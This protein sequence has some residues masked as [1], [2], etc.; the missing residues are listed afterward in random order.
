M[1]QPQR[2][3]TA[4]ARRLVVG[5]GSGPGD[6]RA[7]RGRP[8]PLRSPADLPSCGQVCG[9][10]WG[11]T[12]GASSSV[13]ARGAC[14]TW[15][16]LAGSRGGAVRAGRPGVRPAGREAAPFVRVTEPCLREVQLPRRQRRGAGCDH[17]GRRRPLPRRRGGISLKEARA[18][19]F[20]D[21][22]RRESGAPYRARGGRD[23]GA[24]TCPLLPAHVPLGSLTRGLVE[25]RDPAGAGREAAVRAGGSGTDSENSRSPGPHSPVI[26]PPDSRQS[27]L[28]AH[29]PETAPGCQLLRDQNQSVILLVT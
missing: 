21:L 18:S 4:R 15:S 26:V 5:S 8:S 23:G 10:R 19:L 24:R 22:G 12:P 1:L 6:A 11:G 3:R 20:L 25:S 29:S 2:A 27:G 9:S 13:R 28:S 17:L 14:W 7:R 16:A